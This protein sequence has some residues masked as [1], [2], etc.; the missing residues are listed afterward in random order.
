MSYL[1]IIVQLD[2]H[3]VLERMQMNEMKQCPVRHE[4]EDSPDERVG[5]VNEICMIV[6]FVTFRSSQSP[7]M[8]QILISM[9]VHR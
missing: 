1:I 7:W 3:H 8:E 9:A 4:D 5:V 2:H 6:H